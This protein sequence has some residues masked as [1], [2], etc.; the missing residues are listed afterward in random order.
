MPRVGSTGQSS[1][2]GSVVVDVEEVDIADEIYNC[3]MKI[4]M[5]LVR[6]KNY[7]KFFLDCAF[8]TVG[9]VVILLFWQQGA[10]RYSDGGGAYNQRKAESNF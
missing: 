1:I 7:S 6:Q 2:T 4:I 9:P 10:I 3:P 5:F 8:S